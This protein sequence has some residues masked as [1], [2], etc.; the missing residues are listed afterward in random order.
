MMTYARPLMA[1][2]LALVLLLGAAPR[3]RA[4]TSPSEGEAQAIGRTP[5]R[6]SYINGEV[7]FLRPGAQD[8]SPA[9]ANT[10]LAPGDELYTSTQGDLEMQVGTRAFVRAWG[11]T[12][13]GL[14]NQEPD[15]LQ[16]RVTNGHVSL[17]LRSLDPGRT[18]ELDTPHAAFTIDHPGY[19]RADVT[20]ERTSFITRRAG[21]ATMTSAGGQAVAIAPT[22]EVVL[23]GP[24]T[25]TVQSY[26]APELDTWDQWNYA[27]TDHLL[28]A[29]SARYVPSDVYGVDDLDQHGSWRVVQAYGPVWVPETIPVG[30]VPYSTGRWIWDPYYGWTWVDLAPWGWAPYHYGR[31]VFVDGFWAWAPGPV[32]V[33]PAYAPALVGFFGAPGIRVTVGAPVVSWVA[34]GWG[35]PVVPWWGRAGFIG[36]PWWDGW[37]GPRVVNNVVINRTTVVNVNNIT[38]YRNVTVQNAVVAVRQEH[39]GARPIQEARINQVDVHRLEPVRGP[40]RVAPSASSFVAASAHAA[41]PPEAMAARPVVATRPLAGRPLEQ[42]R[43]VQRTAPVVSTP[44]PRIVSAPNP[45][46]TTPVLSRP[47]FGSSQV[48]RPRRPLPPRLETTQR[49][50]AT[51]AVRGSAG[52]P[53]AQ[54]PAQRERVERPQPT[55]PVEQRGPASSVAQPRSDGNASAPAAGRSE[56][57][58]PSMRPLPGEPANRLFP[59]RAEAGPR[60]EPGSAGGQHAGPGPAS[61]RERGQ[62]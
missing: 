28:E 44:A 42:R 57:P 6:L 25:P 14:A 12:Q 10:P 53:E 38:V 45:A 21:Q 48:E 17:D 2:L 51:A 22:E 9:Q 56:A 30:W 8:W 35:E 13:L 11:D 24:P 36:K 60:Q 16:F 47:P 19:Y 52:R 41:R 49:P 54:P 29:V 23:Q 15:F 18:V 4:A 32:V 46:R 50:E 37:G 20:Q 3:A 40:L 43:E 59:G 58:R 55:P 5:P 62:R 61:S 26:V 39:F 34:L 1:P 31:W 27:R 33:R 7:S